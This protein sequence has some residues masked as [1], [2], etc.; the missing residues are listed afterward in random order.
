MHK[1]KHLQYYYTIIYTDY[2][3]PY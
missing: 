2:K 3:H 1:N